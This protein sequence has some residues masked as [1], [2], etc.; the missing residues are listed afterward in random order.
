MFCVIGVYEVSHSIVDVW[1]MLI[2][3][4][5]GYALKNSRSIRRRWCSGLVI[6]PIFE[7]SLR[8]SLIMSDGNWLIFVTRPIAG[9]LMAA[10]AAHAGDVGD[11]GAPGAARLARQDGRGGEGVA[12]SARRRQRHAEH[13]AAR[14]ADRPPPVAARR[15]R[16]SAAAS[17]RDGAGVTGTSSGRSKSKPVFSITSSTVWPGCTLSSRKRLRVA[18]EREQ[19]AV[20]DE[21]DRAARPM[22][23]VGTAAGRADERHLRHQRAARMLDAEQDHLRHHVI[24]IAGAER[25]GKTHV[26]LRVVADADQIDVAFAVDLAAERKNT[27]TRPWPAQ[28]NS[29]RPPSVKNMCCRLPSS[30]T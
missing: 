3:G 22:H 28:S 9:T 23:V 20:G 25:A 21:P 5:V 12:A 4:M 6:A 26:R 18:V 19:A 29:S 24:E 7:M 11:L 14:T 13:R 15:S 27:S 30:D 10:A 8:Q 16:A 1:I 17:R 2:M